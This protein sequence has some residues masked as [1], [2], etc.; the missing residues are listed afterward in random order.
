MFPA[1]RVGRVGVAGEEAAAERVAGAGV[2]AEY[3]VNQAPDLF[4]LEEGLVEGR[5]V[6]AEALFEER[7]DEALGETGDQVGEAVV[8]EELERVAGDVAG[9]PRLRVA[10]ADA[11]EDL[12]VV[13]LEEREGGDGGLE[14]LLEVHIILAAGRW[15]AD[16]LEVAGRGSEGYRLAGERRAAGSRRSEA[17]SHLYRNATKT[18]SP[19]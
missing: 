9:E 17:A 13:V 19:A 14:V 2:V 3:F 18:A 12:S 16:P 8:G 10:E 5:A 1:G 11:F 15:P 4:V 6:E 7:D